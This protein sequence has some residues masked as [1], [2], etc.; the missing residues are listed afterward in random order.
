M[1][2][3]FIIK[4]MIYK[5]VASQKLWLTF[6]SRRKELRDASVL[7]LCCAWRSRVRYTAAYFLLPF[8]L[9][10]PAHGSGQNARPCQGSPRRV[11]ASADGGSFSRRRSASGRNGAR[12]L[13]R[14]RRI[15]AAPRASHDL[16]GLV[17]RG[18]VQSVRSFR[19][20]GLVSHLQVLG[21]GVQPENSLRLQTPLPRTPVHEHRAE[22]DFEEIQW[23]TDELETF[24][25]GKDLLQA[26]L[27]KLS[28]I[29]DFTPSLLS[30][31]FAP[32]PVFFWIP[33]LFIIV[34]MLFFADFLRP[35]ALT[36]KY[37]DGFL[38]QAS[39]HRWPWSSFGSSRRHHRQDSA[40][41]TESRRCPVSSW[42]KRPDSLV[43]TIH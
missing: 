3:W 40:A 20:L 5:Q 19:L 9:P 30:F 25:D 26:T 10:S 29:C 24:F 39:G 7:Q 14:L 2:V 33:S 35:I 16:F 23:L 13:D 8:I 21:A 37:R 31:L 27:P 38:H 11:D 41:G 34:V 15:H 6:M 32:N 28:L 43:K 1:S 42:S 22:I 18:R 36:R 17:F 4:F 12:L